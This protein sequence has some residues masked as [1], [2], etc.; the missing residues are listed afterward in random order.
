MAELITD[1]VRHYVLDS[2]DEDL[3]RLLSISQLMAD[4]AA[5]DFRRV[6]AREG[7]SAIDCGCGPIGALTVMADVVGPTGR[8]VGVDFS[9]PAIQRA[10]SI[11]KMFRLDNVEPIVGDIYALGP[12]TIGCRFDLAFTRCFLM[13]Q[14]DPVR[15]LGQNLNAYSPRRLGRNPRA[16]VKPTPAV[17]PTPRRAGHLLG[18]PA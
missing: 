16:T 6:G 13:H 7:W 8:V 9:E 4:A 10:R 1:R 5:A 11:V 15:A 18:S 12:T 14:A 3:R 17:I 2:S